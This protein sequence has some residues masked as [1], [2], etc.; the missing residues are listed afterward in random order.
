MAHQEFQQSKFLSTEIN[1]VAS[2]AHGVTDAVDFE[3]FNLENRARGPASSAQHGANA[4]GKFGKCKRLCDI[5]I[6]AGIEP[7]DAFLHFVGAG[8]DHYRQ[9]RTLGANPAQ[10]IQLPASRQIEIEEHE[11]VAL[12][13]S[14][15]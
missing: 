6:G 11:I 8:H 13:G 4:G 14:Q 15:F 10:N 7:A 9:I 12:V 1:V 2:A 3:V 5:V